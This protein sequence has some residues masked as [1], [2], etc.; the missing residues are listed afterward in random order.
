[1]TMFSS[2]VPSCSCADRFSYVRQLLATSFDCPAE[3]SSSEKD[4]EVPTTRGAVPG[5]L[6]THSFLWNDDELLKVVKESVL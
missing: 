3:A 1:M 5:K 6:Q 4:Q 2:P